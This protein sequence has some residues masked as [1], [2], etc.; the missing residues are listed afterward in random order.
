VLGI[1]YPGDIKGFRAW[2]RVYKAARQRIKQPQDVDVI[3]Q[4]LNAT[5]FG[6]LMAYAQYMTPDIAV[7]TAISESNIE[8]FQTLDYIAQEQLSIGSI[9]RELL[10]NRDDI[11]SRFATYLTNPHMNTYGLEGAAEYRFEEMDYSIDAGYSGAMIIPG[12]QETISVQANVR[13]DFT[14]RQLVAATAVGVKLGMAPQEIAQG[15]ASFS[16]LPGHMNRLD[17]VEG[18]VILDDTGNT[19]PLGV[20]TALQSLYR[21]PAPQR[22]AVLGSMRR[23]GPFAQTAHQEAGLLCDP[24]QLAWVVTVGDEANRWLAPAAR[25]RGCQVK[26]CANALDAGAFAHSV[27]EQGSVLLFNGH[28]EDLLEEGVKVVLRRASDSEQLARQSPSE[29]QQKMEAFSRF[30]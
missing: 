24:V 21:T 3:I 11:D 5:S 27:L 7:V 4:E 14:L 26:E 30:S 9:S 13:D 16:S 29:L 8:V 2:H 28:E 22:V 15:V 19:S 6:S 20:R 10:V 12:W 18:S 23:L 17:G 25:G 1:D